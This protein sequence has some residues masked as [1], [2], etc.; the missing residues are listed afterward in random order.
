MGAYLRISYVTIFCSYR[1]NKPTIQID[2]L[3]VTEARDMGIIFYISLF[4][5]KIEPPQTI[6]VAFN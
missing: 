3:L 2:V 1:S 4:A 5:T 6:D